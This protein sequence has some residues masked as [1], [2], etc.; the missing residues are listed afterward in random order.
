MLPLRP[1]FLIQIVAR[2]SSRLSRYKAATLEALD[3]WPGLR[4]LLA[5][6]IRGVSGSGKVE[7]EIRYFPPSCDGDPKVLIQALRRHWLWKTIFIGSW[8]SRSV[9]MTA[10][11]GTGVPLVI[12]P[13]CAR[14][15]STS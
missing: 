12:W 3:A 4:T 15:P 6:S 5:E 11:S 14:S 13:S 9:R 8:I 2:F 10:A 1:P 7:A